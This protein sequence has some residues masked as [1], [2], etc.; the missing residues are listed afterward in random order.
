[1]SRKQGGQPKVTKYDNK[2]LTEISISNAKN[3]IT[4][5]VYNKKTELDG[6]KFPVGLIQ[7]NINEIAKKHNLPNNHKITKTLISKSLRLV[8]IM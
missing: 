4:A 5:I 6:N 8:R 3:G 7:K 1:M 2:K